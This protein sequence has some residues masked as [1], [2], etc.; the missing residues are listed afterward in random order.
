M[1]SASDK[2]REKAE[3]ENLAMAR[4]VAALTQHLHLEVDGSLSP[5]ER[6]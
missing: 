1:A 2:P 4:D 5:W 3:Q 6:E